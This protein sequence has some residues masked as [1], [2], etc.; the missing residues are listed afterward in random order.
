MRTKNNYFS[1]ENAMLVKVRMTLDGNKFNHKFKSVPIDYFRRGP[2]MSESEDRVLTD[3][4]Y[5]DNAT[6]YITY[7]EFFFPYGHFQ[8]EISGKMSEI[9][10]I[11]KL[12]NIP[13]D[14]YADLSYFN[15]SNKKYSKT[16]EEL[17]KISRPDRG[18]MMVDAE[19]I[20]RL[21]ALVQLY[22]AMIDE[23]LFN[24][25]EGAIKKVI[26]NYY[27]YREMLEKE[28]KDFKAK[29]QSTLREF[30]YK[31]GFSSKDKEARDIL[32]DFLLYLR[33]CRVKDIFDIVDMIT[34]KANA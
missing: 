9:L 18:A 33:K 4:P 6:D 27:K 23:V 26:M 12:K 20:E 3:K 21:D 24:G 17:T 28:Y 10:E 29:P 25:S 11:L 22:K 2:T 14:I 5:I 8:D 7:V 30:N 1:K 16:I 15:T 31:L 32:H 34:D 19:S 13:Y